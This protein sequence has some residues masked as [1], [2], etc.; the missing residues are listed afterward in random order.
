MQTREASRLTS[1]LCCEEDERKKE[2]KKHVLSR[3]ESEVKKKSHL[4]FKASPSLHCGNPRTA[5]CTY[6]AVSICK[7]LRASLM[8][9]L[10][11]TDGELER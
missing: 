2:R 11:Q 9:N 1:S 3:L 4:V 7:A 6:T 10:R 8:H 5:R